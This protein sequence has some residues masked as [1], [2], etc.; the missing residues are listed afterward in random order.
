M[1]IEIL[2]LLLGFVILVKG[3]DF[4]VKAAAS[5]AKKL[6]VSEFMIG[7]TLVALGTSI[8]EL[9]SSVIATTQGATGIVIGNVIGSNIANIG[10]ILG[11][12]ATIYVIKTKV[13]MLKRDGYVMLFSVVLFILFMLNGSISRIESGILLVLYITYMI[14]LIEIKHKK[15]EMAHFQH[16]IHFFFKFQYVTTLRTRVFSR[17]KKGKLSANQ[18]KRVEELIKK[19]FALD[20]VILLAS[21]IAIVIGAKFLI[22]EAIYFA[23]LLNIPDTLVGISLIAVGTS[24]PELMVS[25]SAARKGFGDIAVGNIIGSNIANILLVIGVSGLV[26]PLEV[27]KSVLLQSAPFLILISI[28]FLI[29]IRS[30][31]KLSRSEGI[32]FLGAYVIFMGLLFF[33]A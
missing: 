24:L 19:S 29:F 11:L 17:K 21:G 4:F 26:R 13:E 31:W 16:F 7:L 1:I 30:D 25:L 5:I 32:L 2:L 14:F 28:F 27:V 9:A 18:Q 6:G 3:S 10:L 8:P 15:S 22:T 23:K 33:T 20:I 12:T